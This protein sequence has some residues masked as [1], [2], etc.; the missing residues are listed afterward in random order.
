MN[1]LSSHRRRL[2][3]HFG[4]MDPEMRTQLARRYDA[5]AEDAV[6]LAQRF[7]EAPEAV[8]TVVATAIEGDEDAQKLI[9]AL[10]FDHDL[11]VDI[12]WASRSART[13]VKELGLAVRGDPD[14]GPLEH[15][16]PAAIA[17]VIAPLLQ[18]TFTTIP[19]L[20]GACDAERVAR[21]AS[22][23]GVHADNNVETVLALSEWF[24]APER[25]DDLVMMLS[26]PEYLGAALM[27]LELGGICYWQE[28]F[29]HDLH[30]NPE[31]GDNVVALMPSDE[32]EFERHV[33]D[34]LLDLGVIFRVEQ[35]DSAPMVAIPEE[36][37]NALWMIG[38]NW[39]LEWTAQTSNDLGDQATRRLSEPPAGDLQP[40]L[41]WLMCEA[42]RGRLKASA[43]KLSADSRGYL[44]ERGDFDE[45]QWEARLDLAMELSAIRVRKTREVIDNPTFRQVVDLPR[46]AFCRQVLFDWCTGYV[47][48]G[49]DRALPV[50]LGLD[51]EWRKDVVRFLRRRN[52]FVPIWM[53]H[54]GVEHRMTGCGYL[55]DG[56]P[57]ADDRFMMEIGLANGTV[58]SA[59]LVWLDLLSVLESG[60]WYPKTTIAELLQLATGLAIFSQLIHVLQ[61]PGMAY[62]LPVQRASFVSDHFQTPRFEA[63]VDDVVH[64][65]FEPIG[66]ARIAEDGASVWLD[67]SN[68]RVE[69]PPG[70][71]DDTREQLIAE[72]FGDPEME[73]RIPTQSASTLH[74]VSDPHEDSVVDLDLPLEQVCR[75]VGE[76]DIERFDGRRLL[77][78]R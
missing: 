60:M 5:S 70:L 67:T 6:A 22:A 59:K 12:G 54:E 20:L 44:R 4:R 55:R 8:R 29:G 18:G 51:D 57:P 71:P 1:E 17:A 56:P 24:A 38:R 15:E 42:R 9:E 52:E 66:A 40:A 27:V 32:R 10:A 33:A 73:F 43:G 47:G 3:D 65:L 26:N 13:T 50:A 35:E 11:L 21:V 30:E 2:V 25:T 68:L 53:G 34:T 46:P 48:A 19:T 49:V 58:W 76:H 31:Y 78:E 61:E 23:H 41:K 72:I 36:L 75:Q 37:W 45:E 69:S 16:M 7:C 74:R 28:V 64:Y 63:W 39:L 62:Y 77:I 14:A